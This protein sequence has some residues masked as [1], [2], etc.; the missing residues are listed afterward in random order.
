MGDRI[1]SDPRPSPWL[2]SFEGGAIAENVRGSSV[3]DQME[4]DKREL[5]LR[6]VSLDLMNADST[7]SSSI[8]PYNPAGMAIS[9]HIYRLLALSVP[10]LLAI[11]TLH[12][13]I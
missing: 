6:I 7:S 3:R 9:K 11:L 4:N 8:H 5:G 12:L 2:I 1:L 10:L 13:N